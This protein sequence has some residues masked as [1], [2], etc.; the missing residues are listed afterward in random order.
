MWSVETTI[1]YSKLQKD[2]RYFGG[3]YTL[4]KLRL[5]TMGTT[6]LGFCTDNIPKGLGPTGQGSGGKSSGL[7]LAFNSY[8]SL[9]LSV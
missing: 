2:L 1:F 9:L 7:L 6:G 3:R 4:R 5:M 8:E